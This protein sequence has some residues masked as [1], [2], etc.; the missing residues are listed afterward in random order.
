VLVYRLPGDGWA[1]G[2]DA[3]L[4]DAMRAMRLLRSGRVA[5]GINPTRCG[6]LGF[7]AGGHLA[8]NLVFR[9]GMASYPVLDMADSLSPRPD[10]AALIYAAYLDGKGAPAEAVGSTIMPNFLAMAAKGAQPMFL[11]HAED[12]P[13]VPVANTLRLSET[14]K[15]AGTPVETHIFESGGHGFGIANAGD[16]PAKA[17][18]DLFVA[19]GRARGIFGQG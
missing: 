5:S 18:P 11:V 1:A 6:V 2:I 3:P 14:L 10:F 17:W 8:A 16:K 4:Q 13:S 19:W 7:S 12:D 15:A 9:N